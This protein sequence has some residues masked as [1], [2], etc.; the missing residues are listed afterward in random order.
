MRRLP[1][2]LLTLLVVVSAQ[3]A[4][5]Q[6][7]HAMPAA[8]ATNPTFEKLKSLEG[9]WTGKAGPRGGESSAA[10]VTYKLTGGGSALVETL[11]PGTPHEMVT[12][13]FVD[14]AEL[15]LTHY[16]AAGNQPSMKLAGADGSTLRFEFVSGTNMKLSD[17][18]MHAASITFADPNHIVSEWTA[19]RDGKPAEVMVF[20][21]KRS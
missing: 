1:L 13:Y 6:H 8:R 18:H 20:D 11:F 10:T 14:G 4:L 9:T 16:C 17:M 12:V 3:A 7:D 15:R 5:A 19:W 21:L 2:A